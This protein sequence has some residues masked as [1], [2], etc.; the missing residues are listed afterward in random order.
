MIVGQNSLEAKLPAV[1]LKKYYISDN[2]FVE[3]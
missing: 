3:T 1:F 2:F